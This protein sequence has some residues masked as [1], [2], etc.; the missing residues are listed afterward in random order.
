MSVNPTSPPSSSTWRGIIPP[1][2][3]PLRDRDALDVAGLERLVEHLLAGGV[4]GIF[5]LG[6]TGEG[7]SLSHRL[8]QELIQRTCRLVAGRAPVMV[9]ITDPA[10]VESVNLARAAAEAGAQALVLSAP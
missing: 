4:H 9:G 8:R 1:M 10:F 3:T 7:P 6:S 2:V 5:I